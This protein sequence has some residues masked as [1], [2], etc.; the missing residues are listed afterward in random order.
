MG[1]AQS[2]DVVLTPISHPKQQSIYPPN[3]WKVWVQD[4]VRTERVIKRTESR[5][6][7]KMEYFNRFL[8]YAKM[9][10]NTPEELVAAFQDSYR[11]AP[12]YTVHRFNSALP[13][14]GKEYDYMWKKFQKEWTLFDS[15]S[16]HT[17]ASYDVDLIKQLSMMREKDQRY[18]KLLN[19]KTLDQLKSDG[20]WQKQIELDSINSVDIEK[21]LNKHEYPGRSTIGYQ[22]ESIVFLILQHSNLELMEM[23]LPMVQKAVENLDLEA[24]Y[25]A[26][27]YDRIQLLKKLPQLYGTQYNLDGS[28][29]QLSKPKTVNDRRRKLGLPALTLK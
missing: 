18:R 14:Q 4:L 9:Q 24:Q 23:G 8:L 15:I 22:N 10:T 29:Y 17:I 1:F 20:S 19:K 21:I 27:L 16:Q 12:H 13:L 2:K 11:Y 3:Y 6:I 25:L 26:Y 28:L 7:R 5:R